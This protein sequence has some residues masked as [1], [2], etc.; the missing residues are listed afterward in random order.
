MREI[1]LPNDTNTHGNILGG[2]VLHMVDIAA[3]MAAIRHARKPVVTASIDEVE[4][5]EP[6]PEGH[7]IWLTAELNFVGRTSMEVGVTVCGE[8]PITG[9]VVRTTTAYLTFV[10]LTSTKRPSLVPPLIPETDEEKRR[11]EEGKLRMELR[12]QRRLEKAKR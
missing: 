9:E 2:K 10:A 4:F 3:A 6:V 1:V 12:R 8:N 11:F 7:F 5:L